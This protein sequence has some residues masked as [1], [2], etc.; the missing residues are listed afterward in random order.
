[1]DSRITQVRAG[2]KHHTKPE[3]R[4]IHVNQSEKTT[5]SESLWLKRLTKSASDPLTLQ[6][7]KHAGESLRSQTFHTLQ[8]Q[9]GNRYIQR[10]SIGSQGTMP[11]IGALD[12]QLI[13][14]SSSSSPSP[15]PIPYPNIADISSANQTVDKV[16]MSKKTALTQNSSIDASQGDEVGTL[17]GWVSQKNMAK[18]K[19]PGYASKVIS[20]LPN[21]NNLAGGAA[22]NPETSSES[23]DFLDELMAAANALQVSRVVD[24]N[25]QVSYPAPEVGKQGGSI[26]NQLSNR[27]NRSLGN[28]SPLA[29]GKR[30]QMENKF[31]TQFSN[32]RIHTDNEA[33]TLNQQLS[34]RAF[35]IGNDI[36]FN[37]HTSPQD[38]HLLSHELTHVVQQ[39][40]MP[41][42]GPLTVGPTDDHLE[43]QAWDTA[44]ST[45]SHAYTLPFAE[46]RNQVIQRGFMD[47][48]TL[49]NVGGIDGLMA[50]MST[51]ISQIKNLALAK[52]LGMTANLPTRRPL[53]GN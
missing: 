16:K 17:K 23:P 50:D 5:Q 44:N 51:G 14:N 27:I 48:F 33:D 29:N 25:L 47:E 11:P 52:Q 26:S 30:V 43:G 31:G 32:V 1:M 3:Q 21:I 28:G 4:H 34:A 53:A 7:I 37:R 41:R 39:Q 46:Q 22:D 20:Y 49:G 8:R 40:H 12:E 19:Y 13:L 35:T 42:N 15:I 6:H 9:N 36:Y 10:T 18:V 24:E 45:D 2:T 38:E